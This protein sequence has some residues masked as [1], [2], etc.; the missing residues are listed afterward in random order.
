MSMKNTRIS[1]NESANS[2][3]E[4]MKLKADTTAVDVFKACIA[5]RLSALNA[6]LKEHSE[7]ECAPALRA[8]NGALTLYHDE[9]RMERLEQLKTMPSAEADLEYVRTQAVFG[10]KLVKKVDKDTKEVSYEITDTVKDKEGNSVPVKVGLSAYD[11]V[12]FVHPTEMNGIKNACVIF[13]DNLVKSE[14][15]TDAG[16]SR[17]ALSIGFVQL[18]ERMGWTIDGKKSNSQLA[19]Q[20]TEIFNFMFRGVEF[21]AIN[22]DVKFVKNTIIQGVDNK[23]D[24]AGKYLLRNE[25][26]IVN[27]VFRAAYTRINNLAYSFQIKTETEKVYGVVENKDMHEPEEKRVKPDK[28]TAE[29]S[30]VEEKESK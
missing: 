22:A 20:L 2:I 23:P 18:R 6:M 13:A 26:T 3:R 28:M 4:S 11:Y 10:Y 29:K 1:L 17:K 16:I 9:L 5:D 14:F 8:L 15:S 21:K 24:E 7:D 30:M 19:A 27:T 25:E 12:N